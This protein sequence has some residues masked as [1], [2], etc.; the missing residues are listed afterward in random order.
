MHAQAFPRPPCTLPPRARQTF[1]SSRR[2]ATPARRS[3]RRRDARWPPG[4]AVR[5][6]T[7]RNRDEPGGTGRKVPRPGLEL[8]VPGTE[9][10][11]PRR[12]FGSPAGWQ[13][14][15]VSWRSPGKRRRGG[16]GGG[17]PSGCWLCRNT[18][19]CVA[20]RGCVHTAAY[21]VA[22]L[23]HEPLQRAANTTTNNNKPPRCRTAA[24]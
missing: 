13:E 22:P 12:R 9:C 10:C 8:S 17:S 1:D 4:I 19:D 15:G 23:G 11:V 14:P 5:S 2:T 6:R 7:H 20:L 18:S 21:C 3:T 16:G 24:S